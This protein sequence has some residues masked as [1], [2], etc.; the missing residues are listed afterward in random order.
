MR[1]NWN[2]NDLIKAKKKL[3]RL[4]QKEKDS[5]K[6]EYMSIIMGNINDYILQESSK[7]PDEDVGYDERMAIL[8]EE[9][10]DYRKYYDLVINFEDMTLPLQGPINSMEDK[11]EELLGSNGYGVITGATISNHKTMTL[12]DK[13]YREFFPS[14]YPFF[15]HAYKQRRRSVRF[16]SMS[17]KANADSAYFDIIDRYFINY[18]KTR[19]ISKLYS[20]IHEFGHVISYLINPKAIYLTKNIMYTEVASLFPEMVS[21]LENIGSY[22]STQVAYEDYTQLVSLMGIAIALSTHIPLFNLWRENG[23][24]INDSFFKEADKTYCLDT[25]MVDDYLDMHIFDDGDYVVSFMA[26]LELLNIYRKNKSK[27]LKIFE[28]ILKCPYD[29]DLHQLIS[30]RLDLGCHT[31]EEAEIIVDKFTHGLRK[32]RL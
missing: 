19:D 10:L 24:E 15:K 6:L 32:S 29:Q 18:D 3:M 5:N 27:A 1:Y 21:R 14:L 28:E 25:D 23:S 30:S 16:V 12:T 31:A 22:D 17:G 7:E 11:L 8:G 26:V 13:F 2:I 4:I 20:N 9:I